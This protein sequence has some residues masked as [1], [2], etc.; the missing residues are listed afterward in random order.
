MA[1]EKNNKTSKD[2]Q[3]P[4]LEKTDR[5]TGD[6]SIIVNKGDV[7]MILDKEAVLDTLPPPTQKP[8]KP[9]KD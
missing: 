1:D 6:V 5:A 7:R 8:D 3:P 2:E 9:D 4:A